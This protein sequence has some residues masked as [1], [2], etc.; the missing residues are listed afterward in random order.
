MKSKKRRGPKTEPWGTPEVTGSHEEN[1]PL[2]TTRWRRL[3]KNAFNQ[4]KISPE[5]PRDSNFNSKRG[6]ET[7]S[8][9]FARSKKMQ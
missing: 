5:I 7:E 1:L 3:V 2:T 4:I 9:A 8:K 6:W